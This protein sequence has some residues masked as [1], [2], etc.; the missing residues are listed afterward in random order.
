MRF[1]INAVLEEGCTALFA[2]QCHV[3]LHVCCQ[4]MDSVCSVEAMCT[5][6]HDQCPNYH[7]NFD[8]ACRG[9]LMYV[10]L[11]VYQWWFIMV[12]HS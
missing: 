6:E 5:S 10:L 7:L 4:S 1:Q 2:R 11:D 9:L 8:L 12:T 3:A